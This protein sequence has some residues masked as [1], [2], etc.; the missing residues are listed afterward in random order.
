MRQWRLI[1]D[2]PAQGAY[3]MAYDEAILDAV[4]AGDSL[5]TLR[6]YRWSPACLSL[7]Y[8]QSAAD[9]DL[10]QLARH[11][12]DVVR[13]PTGGKAILHTDELTYSVALPADH[14]IAAGDIVESY[15]RISRAL[16]L[17]LE[18]LGAVPH[19]ERRDSKQPQSLAGAVCFEVPSHYEITVEGR[20]LVGSAQMRRKGGVLQHGT[21]PL[22]GDL[23]RI[24]DVLTYPDEIAREQAKAKVHERALTLAEALG[25]VVA[26]N[27][28]AYMVASAFQ[29]V[30]DLDFRLGELS[31]AELAHAEQLVNERYSTLDRIRVKV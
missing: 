10:D 28:V 12:W 30:F 13:R 31:A 23:A 20:K 26:W 21:L 22:E 3:N 11:G 16:L 7:G 29:Q 27:D 6:L 18:N 9:A 4:T 1:Y 8:G 5:P 17:A 2:H 19:S 25:R 15:R 24:C 14:P